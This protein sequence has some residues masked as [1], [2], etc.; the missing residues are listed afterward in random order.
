MTW[1]SPFTSSPDL[2]RTASHSG[3]QTVSFL[4]PVGYGGDTLELIDDVGELGLPAPG[5]GDLEGR[6]PAVDLP[7]ERGHVAHGQQPVPDAE[8]LVKEFLGV[9]E[10]PAMTCCPG[11]HTL[12]AGQHRSAAIGGRA[13]HRARACKGIASRHSSCGSPLLQPRTG[14]R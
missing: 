2:H 8:H 11:F 13:A 10:R 9:T 7:A 14:F 3:L 5:A 4:L 12:P 1:C 6:L